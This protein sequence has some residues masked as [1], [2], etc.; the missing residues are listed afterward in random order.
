MTWLDGVNRLCIDHNDSSI[1]KPVI[2]VKVDFK[3][4]AICYKDCYYLYP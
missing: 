3:T 1:R 2:A 4:L